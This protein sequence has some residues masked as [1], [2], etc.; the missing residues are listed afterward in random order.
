ML[1]ITWYVLVATCVSRRGTTSLRLTGASPV[2]SLSAAPIAH[3]GNEVSAKCTIVSVKFRK[4]SDTWWARLL[5][6]KFLDH[7]WTVLGSTIYY[8]TSAESPD[9]G[10]AQ[11]LSRYARVI[12]HENIHVEQWARYGAPLFLAIYAG[13]APFLFLL[14]AITACCG[15]PAWAWLALLGISVLSTPLSVGLAFGRVWLEAEAS[16]PAL[17]ESGDPSTVE[18]ALHRQAEK[19]WRDY[20]WAMP[21][22]LAVRF[23]KRMF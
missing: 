15:V 16:M 18:L 2:R 23:V 4:K 5:G 20:A 3:S 13:P 6:P 12:R 9:A 17:S 10:S 14:T 21:P 1:R 19:W 7:Y 22:N 8:P 11:W